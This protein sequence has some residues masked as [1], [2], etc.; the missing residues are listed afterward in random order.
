MDS[1]TPIQHYQCL[2]PSPY[3]VQFK[4]GAVVDLVPEGSLAS[5]MEL[6]KNGR[7]RAGWRFV[8]P[9]LDR[10]WREYEAK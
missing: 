10:L 7:R 6:V 5:G 1:S 2:S 3:R 4:T 8:R 9:D